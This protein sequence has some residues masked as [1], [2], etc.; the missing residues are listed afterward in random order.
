LEGGIKTDCECWDLPPL[1]EED[2]PVHLQYQEITARIQRML[3]EDKDDPRVEPLARQ[4]A[5][6][7]MGVPVTRK[8]GSPVIGLHELLKLDQRKG[9]RKEWWELRGR[10]V[11]EGVHVFL[12]YPGAQDGMPGEADTLIAMPSEAPYEYLRLHQTR[13]NNRPV[14]TE[15]IIAALSR[16]DEE[17]G[18][19]VV[20]ATADSVEFIFAR[21]VEA[22]SVRRVW[23]RLSRLCPSAEALSE[24]IQ[25]GRVTL[26]WD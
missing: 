9:I 20:S 16:L 22:E 8:H 19:E 12:G 6:L 3:E 5:E 7:I 17:Y 13:G 26:W 4:A 15:G 11:K 1:E 18:V 14:D 21:T 10:F 24:G 2:K 23:Q 25:L